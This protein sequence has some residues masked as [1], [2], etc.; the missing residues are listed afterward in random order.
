VDEVE[1]QETTTA[2]ASGGI[3]QAELAVWSRERARSTWDPIA[4]RVY[5]G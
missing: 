2:L 4:G 5:E 1:L 3:G